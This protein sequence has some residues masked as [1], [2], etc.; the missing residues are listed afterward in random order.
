MT[1]VAIAWVVILLAVGFVLVGRD[2]LRHVLDRMG[3][4]HGGEPAPDIGL[5]MTR[6]QARYLIGVNDL[7]KMG[8]SLYKQARVMDSGSDLQRLSFVVVAGELE[9]PREALRLLD[10]LRVNEPGAV[11][12]KRILHRLY[13][14]YNADRLN[15][16]SVNAGDRDELKRQLGW[17]GE[18]A[19]APPGSGDGVRGAVLAPARRTATLMLVFFGMLLLAGVSGFGL[20]LLLV[21][22]AF[23][24]KLKAHGERLGASTGHIYAE[25][26]AVWMVL[27]LGLGLVASLMPL[28]RF[29]LLAFGVAA[30]LSLT[31]LAWPVIRGVPW[32][33]VRREIGL[34]AGKRPWLEPLFGPACY[35]A[36]LPLL[37]IGVLVMVVLAKV[38]GL[39][40]VFGAGMAANEG[41]APAHPLV[42]QIAEGGWVVWLQAVFVASVVAPIVEE[43]MFRGVFYRHMRELTGRWGAVL[44]VLFSA[45]VVS[46]LFAVIHPQG[47]LAVPPLMALAFGFTLARE[48]RGSLVPCMIA[49]GLNNLMVT[50]LVIVMVT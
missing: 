46:F 9:G 50:L 11:D 42:G 24:R 8:P 48:W 13:T 32:G 45:F 27:F 21:V 1:S 7:L 17:L 38:L 30:L 19:L 43:T 3:L 39:G 29:E 36:T 47:F 12:V 34:T 16:P 41:H 2:L 35:L 5:V 44:S 31:A 26:F 33:Q 25:T 15:G 22:L 14:D 18:V 6:M 40:G 4:L 10:D 28:G 49:H 20:L 37:V 23:A